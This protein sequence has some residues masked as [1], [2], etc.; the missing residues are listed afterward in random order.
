MSSARLPALRPALIIRSHD[1]GKVRHELAGDAHC[2]VP[3]EIEL[4]AGDALHTPAGWWHEVQNPEA[5]ILLSGFF[6]SPLGVAAKWLTTLPL[7][8]LHEAGLRRRGH[9]VCHGRPGD[10][11]GQPISTR[12]TRNPA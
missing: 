9:C 6:G 11:C 4:R 10:A 2:P 8:L 7:H 3:H 12:S 5:S 1:P